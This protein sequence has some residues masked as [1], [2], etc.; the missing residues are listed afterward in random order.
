MG[1]WGGGGGGGVAGEVLGFGVWV[2]GFR[3]QGSGRR[4]ASKL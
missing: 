3:V 1:G 2:L 4:I